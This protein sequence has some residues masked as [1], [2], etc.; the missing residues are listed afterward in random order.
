MKVVSWIWLN[1][2][3]SSWALQLAFFCSV[4]PCCLV[5][6]TLYLHFSVKSY[7]NWYKLG[8]KKN[9]RRS[10]NPLSPSLKGF[11]VWLPCLI[12]FPSPNFHLNWRP[13]GHL[14]S[15]RAELEKGSVRG[16]AVF[17]LAA[18]FIVGAI[19]RT[20]QL[21]MYFSFLV[22]PSGRDKREHGVEAVKEKE[23]CSPQWTPFWL[24]KCFPRLQ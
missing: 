23:R 3:T 8:L 22:A 18:H 5:P 11:Q 9:K 20:C 1:V 21:F 16:M 17:A 2:L 12:H 4:L 7:H 6:N 15:P 14:P 19:K 13:S 24:R 10:D